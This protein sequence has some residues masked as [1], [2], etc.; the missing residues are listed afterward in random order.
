MRRD[1]QECL[2][3]MGKD[4]PRRRQVCP[5]SYCLSFDIAGPFEAGFDQLD[6][7]AKYFLLGT[8]TLPVAQGKAMAEAIEKL[9]GRVLEKDPLEEMDEWDSA[10]RGNDETGVS[11]SSGD[12]E[13]HSG[14][15][16]DPEAS[17]EEQNKEEAEQNGD[18]DGTVKGHSGG[19]LDPGSVPEDGKEDSLPART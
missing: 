12:A 9:G 3:A 10:V 18:G 4:R 13:G 15:F 2:L 19:C 1:C 8:Y 7:P 17:P 6:G 5:P 14:G 11:R 16:L